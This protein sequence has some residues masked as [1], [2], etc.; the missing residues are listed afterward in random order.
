MLLYSISRRGTSELHA[1]FRQDTRVAG[2]GRRR[3]LAVDDVTQVIFVNQHLIWLQY[4]DDQ[5]PRDALSSTTMS[6]E[7][8]TLRGTFREH[9]LLD[10]W[11]PG[12]FQVSGTAGVW[13]FERSVPY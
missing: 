8:G 6:H 2:S 7:I 9:A 10:V 11:K 4:C 12:S 13:S 1:H 3:V 5:P